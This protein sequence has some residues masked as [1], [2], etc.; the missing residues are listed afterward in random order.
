MK[1]AECL[2]EN[3]KEIYAID[4][5]KDKKMSVLVNLLALVIAAILVVPMHFAVPISTLF[6][7]ESGMQC[8]WIRYGAMLAL[9]V[10]YMILHELVHGIAMKL[11]RNVR[12]CRKQGVLRQE[13][14]YLHS[15][16]ACCLVGNRSCSNQS[17][18]SG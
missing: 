18:C 7:A 16:G 1:A 6:G 9:M 13:I 12:L 4:L 2:P 15:F 17:L 10:L 11:Y 3:Y 5:Q 14:V 8:Y